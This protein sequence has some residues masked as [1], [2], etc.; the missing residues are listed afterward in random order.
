MTGKRT[1][2]VRYPSIL[3]WFLLFNDVGLVLDA[4]WLLFILQ[5]LDFRLSLFSFSGCLLTF[6]LFLLVFLYFL[7]VLL[8]YLLRLDCFDGLEDEDDSHKL[9]VSQ[10]TRGTSQ[11]ETILDGSYQL[12]RSGLVLKK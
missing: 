3:L 10:R 2:V 11:A 12:Y 8:F 9:L 7:F 6:I 4:L 1:E 5:R